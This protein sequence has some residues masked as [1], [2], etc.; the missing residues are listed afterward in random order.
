MGEEI[1]FQARQ[2][3]DPGSLMTNIDPTQMLRE[4]IGGVCDSITYLFI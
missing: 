4:Y 3:D 2:I 1:P